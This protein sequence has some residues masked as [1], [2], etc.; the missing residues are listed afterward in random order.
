MGIEFTLTKEQLKYAEDMGIKRHN[1]DK[2]VGI[3]GAYNI[4]EKQDASTKIDIQGCIAE[5]AVSLTLD[6]EWIPFSTDFKNLTADVGDDKQVRSTYHPRGNLLLHPKDRDDQIF[7][8]VKLDRLPS[9]D[10]V[11]WIYGRE[12]KQQQYW[13]EL[14][15]NRLCFVYPAHKLRKMQELVK[16]E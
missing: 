9:V 16:E 3:K 13:T 6:E 14:V 5:Y 2:S 10:L 11:G 12:G 8:L 15:K 7:I 1:Y 4:T